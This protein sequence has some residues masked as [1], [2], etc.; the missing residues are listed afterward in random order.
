[1]ETRDPVIDALC[2]ALHGRKDVRLALLFGSRARG[3]ARPG[4][5]ADVAVQGRGVDLLELAA[6]LSAAARIEVDVVSLEDP[7]YPLLN[8]LLRERAWRSKKRSLVYAASSN[9]DRSR[10]SGPHHLTAGPARRRSLRRR[11][12][13]RGKGGSG[14]GLWRFPECWP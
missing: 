3:R 1:M 10:R 11:W 8:A 5:D 9:G 7:G 12:R 6:D 4:S 2:R 14:P 13:C